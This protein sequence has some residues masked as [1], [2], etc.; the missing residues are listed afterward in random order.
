M[1]KSSFD[2]HKSQVATTLS[3][4]VR[5]G[6]V[7]FGRLFPFMF[8]FRLLLWLNLAS[9]FGENTDTRAWLFTNKSKNAK[10]INKLLNESCIGI[11]TFYKIL[12]CIYI[13]IF[14]E[15]MT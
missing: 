5:H 1:N 9:K 8:F 2:V 12:A 4:Y 3:M 15:E 11:Q 7:V 6:H 13:S 14:L 10:A